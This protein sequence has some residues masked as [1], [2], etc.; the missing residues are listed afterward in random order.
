MGFDQKNNIPMKGKKA[1][2]VDIKL[3]KI[4][5]KNTLRRRNADESESS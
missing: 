4:I 1:L 5:P 3:N 2:E